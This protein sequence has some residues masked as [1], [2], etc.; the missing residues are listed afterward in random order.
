MEI[1]N[2]YQHVKN[3]LFNDVAPFWIKYGG[4]KEGKWK[5]QTY[6]NM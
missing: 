6:I 1:A 5:L 2:L 4:I 3:T